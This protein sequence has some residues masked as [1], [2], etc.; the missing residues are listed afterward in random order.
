MSDEQIA[1]AM[2]VSQ[3]RV[4]FLVARALRK[5]RERLQAVAEQEEK[6]CEARCGKLAKPGR[7]VCSAACAGQLGADARD[8]RI[9]RPVAAWNGQKPKRKRKA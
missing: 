4:T 3:Q 5:L 2:G 1:A 8:Y 6:E 9:A 7:R